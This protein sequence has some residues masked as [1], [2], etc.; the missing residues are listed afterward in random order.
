MTLSWTLQFL[1]SQFFAKFPYPAYDFTDQT[2]LVTGSN[3]GLALNQWQ[4]M[5]AARHIARLGAAKVILGVRTIS[6]GDAAAEDIANSCNV[7]RANLEVWQ[8]DMGDTESI[9][10]FAARAKTLKRLDGAILNAGVLSTKW[11][12]H[13][14][15]ESHLAINVLGTMLLTNLLL[16]TME[17]S[18]AAT[19]THGRLAVV[20]SDIMYLADRKQL[21]VSGSILEALKDKSTAAQIGDRYALSKLLV[22]YSANDLAQRHPVSAKSGVILSVLTPGACHSDIFRDG[23][24]FALQLGWATLARTTEVGA[25]TLVFGV[26]PNLPVETHGRFLMDNRINYSR[27]ILDNKLDERLSRKWIAELKQYLGS[28][29]D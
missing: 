29:A 14:G 7:P 16:P 4:G 28:V 27:Q 19:G 5:E 6:K 10:S 23:K 3:V 26:D 20:G 21:D 2:I 25:R 15:V 1:Y 9:K 22:F 24:S 18:A 12:D 8:L 13:A 11:T 17:K